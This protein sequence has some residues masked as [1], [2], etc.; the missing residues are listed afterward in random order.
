[1]NRRRP[2]LMFG[3]CTATLWLLALA[4]AL[5]QPQS[6]AAE[7][8]IIAGPMVGHI[9]DNNARVWMQLSTACE[10]RLSPVDADTQRPLGQIWLEIDRYP[11]IFDAPVNGLEPNHNYRLDVLLDGHPATLRPPLN[12]K[13]APAPGDAVNFTV[14]FGSCLDQGRSG[15]MPIYAAIQAQA[16]Q[17][18]IFLGNNGRLPAALGDF[19]AS[20]R[21]ARRF[22]WD[23]HRTIR[24]LPDIQGLLRSTAIYAMWDDGD[25]G[26]PNPDKTFLFAKEAQSAFGFYWANPNAG[27]LEMY[28]NFTLGDVDIFVLDNRTYRDPPGTPEPRTLLGEA[29][30]AWLKKSLKLSRASFKVIACPT[31]MLADYPDESW[32]NYKAEHDAFLAWLFANKVNGV[33]FISGHRRLAELSCRPPLPPLPPPPA[34]PAPAGKSATEYPLYDLTSS[35]L[36]ADQATPAARDLPNPQRLGPPCLEV[37]FGELEFAGPQEKRHVNLLLRDESGKIRLG[38]TTIFAGTLKGAE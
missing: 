24:N 27:T 3:F 23:F 18:F 37:N 19:P 12:V 16:P 25:Y 1:M 14:A 6:A 2:Q 11:F 10:V 7:A 34:S 15:N 38:P 30:L 35:P 32:N 36:A 26:P 8:K 22:M 9:T 33:L 31:P 21:A 28:Y 4:A 17:A 20:Y 5:A 29:Q 13:T